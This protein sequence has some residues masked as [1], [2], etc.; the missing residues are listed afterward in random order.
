MPKRVTSRTSEPRDAN[1]SYQD[2]EFAIRKIDRRIAD[3]EG[4]DVDSVSDRQDIRIR[5]LEFSIKGLLTDIFGSDTFQFKDYV[6][7]AHLDRASINYMHETPID[8][9]R[10]GLRRG[11]SEAVQVL[12]TIKRD[13]Q[14]QLNDAGRS[15]SAKPLRA[16]EALE[17]HQEIERQVGQLYRDGHYAEA[18]EK[19]IK[20]LNA[21]VRLRSNEELDGTALMQKV[22][23]SKSPIL[24]FNSLADQS[25]IDEQQGFMFLF[26]G[27]VMGLRNPRAH[28]IIKDDPERALEFIAFVSLLAKMLDD[29]KI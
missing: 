28:R 29:A 16:Y 1:L 7:I 25:D 6:G 20:T 26:S 3:L 2:M 23:S 13:F 12:K 18:V 22:F 14:E 17:L 15:S 9:V 19:S 4:F 21:L 27:A 8:E 10:D 24:K 11:V 5:P